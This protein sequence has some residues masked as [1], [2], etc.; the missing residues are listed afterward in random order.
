[1]STGRLTEFIHRTRWEDIPAS[2]RHEAKRS[3]LNFFACALGGCRDAV[4]EALAAS[5]KPF[6][7]SAEATV[8][9]RG[10]R[11][12]ALTATFLNAAGANVFD[13]DDTHTRTVIHPAA[14]VA[15]ALF[16]LAERSPMSGRELLLAF[17][18]GVETECRVGNAVSPAHYRRGWHITSTCGVFG[19][20]AAIAK[21]LGLTQER[22]VW[23]LGNASAQA[24]GLLETL[25]TMG[26]SVSVGNAARNG[27]AAALYAQH[28]V[29]GPARP[30][31]GVY[32]FLRV[33]TGESVE[34]DALTA[35]LG[36]QWEAGLNTYKLYPAGIV[37]NPV[38][39][40]CLALAQEERIDPVAIEHVEIVGH[41][42]LR[43]RTDRVH[44]ASGREAQVSA[45]HAVAV[46]FTRG[47]AGLEEFSD[48]CA[49]D[50]SLRPLREKVSFV[51]DSE[52]SVE[53]AIVTIGLR[54]GHAVTKHVDCA[55]G[56]ASRPLSDAQI[57][58]KLRDLV[59]FGR[60][61]CDA[62]RLI[63][64]VWALESADDAAS[65]VR[66]AA[67]R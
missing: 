33:T 64:A 62:A 7:G 1:M 48:S 59:Q 36:E 23:A 31:E 34:P 42:L 3:L 4:V 21:A 38:I 18:L 51:D 22:I 54:G 65:L 8:I 37:L 10:E 32:G 19:A 14:P 57:E 17:V 39:E 58:Q 25:G 20:A 13:F 53:S 28:G 40:A 6:A 47:R 9:G 43:E 30:L 41:P 67:G 56:S 29:S 45:Q 35:G 63:D 66:L 55:L 44:P 5:V 2:V 12:D 60:S 26:K 24:G 27:F 52:R 61:G 49:N 15:P 50:A 46:A 11:A 16:A